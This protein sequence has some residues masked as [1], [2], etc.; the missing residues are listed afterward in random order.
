MILVSGCST[1]MSYPQP[2]TTQ[3][4]FDDFESLGKWPIESTVDIY[5]HEKMIPFVDAKTDDDCAFAIGVIHAHLRLGQMELFKRMSAGRLSE[6]G[7]PFVL[8]DLD[9]LIRLID[10]QKSAELSLERLSNAE[11]RWLQRYVDGINFFIDKM[12]NLPVT[13]QFMNFKPE[14]WTLTD[15]LRVGRLASADANWASLFSFLTLENEPGWAKIWSRYINEGENSLPSFNAKDSVSFDQYLKTINRAGSNSFV[16][17]KDKSESGGA[18]MANDPHLGIFAPNLWLLMGYKSPSF[19]VIGYM[20]PSVPVVAL[21]RN[22]DISWGGTYMR[23]VSTHLFEVDEN[24]TAT[25]RTEVISR[26]FWF[27]KKIIIRETTKGPLLTDHPF[28]KKNKKKIALQ[29]TGQQGSNEFGAYFKANQASNFTDF[30]SSFEDYAVAGLNLTYADKEGNIALLPAIRQPLLNDP[31]ELTT[32]VKPL[33]S[34]VIEYLDPMDLPY[35]FNPNQGFIV[36]TNNIPF[37]SSPP[38]AFVSGLNDRFK[39]SNDLFRNKENLTIIDLMKAQND[40]YSPDSHEFSSYLMKNFFHDLDDPVKEILRPLL[41]W[42]GSYQTEQK[43]PLIYEFLTYEMAN[44]FFTNEIKNKK[45]VQRLM[46][47]DD[48][49]VFF[50]KDFQSLDRS[51]Q[52]GLVTKASLKIKKIIN[53][54]D[55][56]GS[57]HTQVIRS[58]LGLVPVLGKR[59]EFFEFPAAGSSSTLNKAAFTPG[60]KKARVTFGAQVRHI[61]DMSDLDENYFVMLGG[62]DGWLSNPN[63]FDQV[64]LW[65]KG[66]YIKL[67]LG[68][69]TVK[70]VFSKRKNSISP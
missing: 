61:S 45:L 1:L 54:Y 13:F 35:E 14:L 30:R 5:W 18:L 32:L 48:W 62:N 56:W 31:E 16:L 4:R 60:Y 34:K 64:D 8:P 63:L 66:E 65:S 52:Y 23:G 36:S 67:P 69:E 53:K 3:E 10:L 58:P 37:Q 70:K 59:F 33:S 57:Y 15:A 40:V 38:I 44:L 11:R 26:R 46:N 27:N 39:R 68:L 21:G 12:P 19:H 6:S 2:K 20:L 24:E 55:N 28:F 29:W 51:A 25:V 42:D 49:R 41:N 50:K 9:H 7:G 22:N 17:S 47:S 43:E